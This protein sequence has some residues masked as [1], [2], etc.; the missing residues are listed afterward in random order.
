ME[1]HRSYYYYYHYYY[2]YFYYYY[3]YYYCY[4]YYYYTIALPT[5]TI[6][7]ILCFQDA[8]DVIVERITAPNFLRTA[9]VE[10][11]AARW[12]RTI[13]ELV[14]VPPANLSTACAALVLVGDMSCLLSHPSDNI[15]AA[16]PRC[17]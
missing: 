17:C 6:A 10:F 12:S 8:L 16:M 7:H 2:Y 15:K 3:Y 14:P 5:T 13:D 11:E 1:A 4:Y 9:T